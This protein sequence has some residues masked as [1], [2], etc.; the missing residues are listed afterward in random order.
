MG[1][2]NNVVFGYFASQEVQP[3]TSDDFLL[4]IEEVARSH[5]Y[6]R[7]EDES[8]RFEAW[9]DGR[10][11]Y[12]TDYRVNLALVDF[13]PD[14]TYFARVD[15]PNSDGTF[16]IV[17]SIKPKFVY[18]ESWHYGMSVHLVCDTD[19][20]GSPVFR[21]DQEDSGPLLVSIRPFND[22]FDLTISDGLR[23]DFLIPAIRVP[24]ENLMSLFAEHAATIR[25]ARVN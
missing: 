2:G 12:M 3:Q 19:N 22:V 23:L 24:L 9:L 13:D 20:P 7:S 5:G 21:A 10:I 11:S 17:F 15:G 25:D 6:S 18:G 16:V 8:L 14:A 4:E 1:N